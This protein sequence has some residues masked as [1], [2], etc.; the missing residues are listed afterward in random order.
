VLGCAGSHIADRRPCWRAM[1][2]RRQVGVDARNKFLTPQIAIKRTRDTP[3]HKVAFMEGEN[4]KQS[5]LEKLLASTYC[6][7]TM[8]TNGL[9]DFDAYF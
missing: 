6:F 5:H 4:S 9:G 8:T 7:K 1:C 3:D 2:F